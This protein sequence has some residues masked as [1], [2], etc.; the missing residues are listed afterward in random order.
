M[1]NPLGVPAAWPS[2]VIEA[3]DV[4]TAPTGWSVMTPEEYSAH[5]ALHQD[6]YDAWAASQPPPVPPPVLDYETNYVT[7]LVE[8]VASTTSTTWVTRV[9]V[10]TGLL[11]GEFNLRWR[12]LA[13]AAGNKVSVGEY[14]LVENGS[15]VLGP[16]QINERSGTNVM[17]DVADVILNGVSKTYS[18]QWRSQAVG[19]HSIQSARIELWRTGS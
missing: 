11:V 2:S 17:A 9:S 3:D 4:A 19:A 10:V 5:L 1:P 18:L 12:C 6:A 14:R 16:V 7:E 13:T 15:V 8:A